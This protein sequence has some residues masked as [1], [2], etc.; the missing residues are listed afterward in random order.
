MYFQIQ[1]YIWDILQILI[2]FI[3]TLNIITPVFL[4][5]IGSTN[6]LID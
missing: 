3:A 1:M 2:I 6:N 4:N 5:T